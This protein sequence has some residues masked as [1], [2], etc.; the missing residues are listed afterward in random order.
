M[1]GCVT[2]GGGHSQCGCGSMCTASQAPA[3]AVHPRDP[4]LPGRQRLPAQRAGA[5]PDRPGLPQQHRV[6]DD[7]ARWPRR[8]HPPQRSHAHLQSSGRIRCAARWVHH[9]HAAHPRARLAWDCSA[10]AG[11]P[12]CAEARC[13]RGCRV[14]ISGTPW[15]HSWSSRWPRVACYG[16]QQQCRDGSRGWRPVVAVLCLQRCKAYRTTVLVC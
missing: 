3:G 2:M 8:S 7:A 11:R 4:T 12:G 16:C 13:G 14:S 15:W 5:C 6:G 10:A 1:C 9:R